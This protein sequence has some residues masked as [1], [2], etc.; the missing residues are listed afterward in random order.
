MKHALGYAGSMTGAF[1]RPSHGSG[2]RH[3][4]EQEG[5]GVLPTLR[6]NQD[7]VRSIVVQN[8]PIALS[9]IY[10][11]QPRDGVREVRTRSRHL[12]DTQRGKQQNARAQLQNYHV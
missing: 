4:V 2:Y 10:G 8:G 12:I 3:C 11:A 9:V 1:D 5:N 6:E 7:V